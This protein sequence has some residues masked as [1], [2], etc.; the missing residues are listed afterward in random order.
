MTL[1]EGAG[2]SL[3]GFGRAVSLV[4]L[5]DEPPPCAA[6][7]VAYWGAPLTLPALVHTRFPDLDV[8]LTAELPRGGGGAGNAPAP[9]GVTAVRPNVAGGR[10]I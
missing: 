9:T 5:P 4:P 10:R 1:D 6:P 3:A 8:L 7:A 2:V